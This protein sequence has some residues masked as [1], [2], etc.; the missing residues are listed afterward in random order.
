MYVP[1]EISSTTFPYFY[2]PSSSIKLKLRIILFLQHFEFG[3][4]GQG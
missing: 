2:V 1:D 3:R 4:Y